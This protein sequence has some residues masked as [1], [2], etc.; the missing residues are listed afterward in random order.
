MLINR[1][2]GAHRTPTGPRGPV[3][4]ALVL[5]LVLACWLAVGAF[6]GMAQGT[7]SE[8]QENDQAAF[9]PASAEST[10]A[11]E[12]AQEFTEDQPLPALVVTTP[13]GGGQVSEEQVAAAQEY[14][15]QL[16]EHPLPDGRIIA[17]VLDGEI[18][19]V[20]AEDGQA[21]LLP[22]PID[23]EVANELVGDTG[24]RV[25]N[26][27]VGELRAVAADTLGDAELD[28]WVTGPAGFVADLV[29]AFGG[30]DGVLLV[31]ALVVV[32]LI[33]VAVYRSPTLPFAVLATS[34]FALCAAALVVKPL[35]GNDVL[36]LNGQSQGILSILVIGAA[37]DYSLLIVARYREEL[38][39]HDEPVEAM[40]VAWRASVPA[41]LA[42]AG[43]VSA[44]L[45]CLL[46]SDLGSNASL[47]PVG[48]I[49]IVASALGA[50]TLLPAILLIG[51]RR[52][53]FM[54][55]P[56]VPAYSPEATPAAE[57]ATRLWGRVAGFVGRRPRAVWGSTAVVL[58]ALAAFLPTLRA[59]G[60]GEADVF[61][62]ET[63]AVTGQEVLAE[64]F[65]AGQVDPIIVL[66][67]QE[68]AEEVTQAVAAVDGIEGA[69]VLRGEDEQPVVV[70]G[71]VQIEAVTTVAAETQEATVAAAEVREAVRA[72]DSEALVGGAAAERLDTQ[73][74]ATRD[75]ITIIP[76]VLAV[77][78]L[79][80][81]VLLRSVVAPLLILAVNV[82]SFAATMGLAAIV[83]NHV[84][85]F[86]G[87]DATVPLFGF[88]F[89]VALSIDYSIFLMTRV[90]EE[91][92]THGTRTGVR[93][94]LAMT[95]GVITS[96]GLV[97]AAT[98]SALVV[99]PLLFLVQ[100]AFIVAVG[101]LIDTF[102]V[103][104]LLVSGLAYDIGRPVWWPWHSRI[105]PEGRD[106]AE[107]P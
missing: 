68:D 46:L 103:R 45:L 61:L 89:L 105:P 28:A 35:A 86:P 30:I 37:T 4:R 96:A 34:V 59:E 41:I 6:G 11:T 69:D 77:I 57:D 85:G 18:A 99:I 65:A 38:T 79:M 104:S 56:R 54:F 36:L 55:W 101:V 67:G 16:T 76:L 33:L 25:V 88:I 58:L 9:L 23:Q 7:L 70:D 91:S 44:G 72:V 49:G 81:V 13:S 73:E 83:F 47:G 40:R 98:F 78:F 1:S 87:A 74:T 29:A 17:D 93:R 53:R 52:S 5:L 60:T 15:A 50:L 31:V 20:P 19:V 12:L 51:G 100:L 107:T 106:A 64:H 8:V 24:D 102:I 63:E 14:A 39:R 32:L 66:T 94:G 22:V 21:L 92:L 95:G 48:M 80:L 75:L 84:L 42:S 3:L 43:T 71:R 90:R 62:N 2:P 26:V 97:L 27:V 10:R 82:L